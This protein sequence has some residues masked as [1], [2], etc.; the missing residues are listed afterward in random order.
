MVPHLPIILLFPKKKKFR[1]VVL[2][3]LVVEYISVQYHCFFFREPFT[4][5]PFTLILFTLFNS[6]M[7]WKTSL[8]DFFGSSGCSSNKP[9]SAF[10]AHSRAAKSAAHVLAATIL[11]S[12][13]K[14]IPCMIPFRYGI[15]IGSVTVEYLPVFKYFF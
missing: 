6:S 5:N 8:H 3:C 14:S 4:W 10:S 1:K 15:V 13:P 11:L 9:C 12:Y 7:P 2:R